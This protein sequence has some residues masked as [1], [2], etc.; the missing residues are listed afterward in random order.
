MSPQNGSPIW[1]PCKK[2]ET[3]DVCM[4]IDPKDLNKALMRPYHPMGAVEELAAQ[5]SGPLVLTLPLK[6]SK[7]LWNKSLLDTHAP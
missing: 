6:F 7:E 1:L 3:D 2:K 5:M 4:C